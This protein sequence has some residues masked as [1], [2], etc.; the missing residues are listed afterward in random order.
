MAEVPEDRLALKLHP[1]FTEEK[2][3]GGPQPSN[4]MSCPGDSDTEEPLFD[5]RVKQPEDYDLTTEWF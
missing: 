5:A 2:L 4:F 1:R 3:W